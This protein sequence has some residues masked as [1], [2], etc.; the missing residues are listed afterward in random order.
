MDELDDAI[1][2]IVG[3]IGGI[4]LS[5]NTYRVVKSREGY[6]ILDSNKLISKTRG[7]KYQSMGRGYI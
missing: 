2:G 4:R 7:R 3:I 1:V 6:G 5:K